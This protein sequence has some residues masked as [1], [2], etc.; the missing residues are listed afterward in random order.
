MSCE[1][2]IC[3]P[4]Y[5]WPPRLGRLLAVEEVLHAALSRL[6]PLDMMAAYSLP[7]Q[8]QLVPLTSFFVGALVWLAVVDEGLSAKKS[9]G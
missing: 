5:A 6:L 8:H 1:H 7:L 3:L 4:F 2:V 9:V